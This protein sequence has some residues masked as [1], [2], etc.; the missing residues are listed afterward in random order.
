MPSFT[1]FV[2]VAS[3]RD[4]VCSD[5][6][7]SLFSQASDPSRIFVGVCEQNHK[8]H[9]K[10]ESCNGS[11]YPNVRTISIP[12]Y[13]AAGPTKARWLCST[14]YQGEDFYCQI[15]SHTKFV[16][17]WDRLA[18]DEWTSLNEKVPKPVLSTYP[19]AIEEAGKEGLLEVPVICEAFFN[20]R[21]ILSFKGAELLTRKEPTRSYFVAGGFFFVKGS[22]LEEIP[23]DPYLPFLFVGE[24]ILHS[25]RF[26]THGYDV[27]APSKNLVFHEYTRAEKPKIWSDRAY[28]DDDAVQKVQWYMKLQQ[29]RPP[30]ALMINNDQYGLGT[31]R[32]IE[33]FY[34]AIGVDVTHRHVG[35]NV[36]HGT[37][38]KRKEESKVHH[39]FF[40]SAMVLLVV[41]AFKYK[42]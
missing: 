32:T 35:K 36:C 16:K 3:Y 7:Q 8:D 21:G 18:I 20:P 5:T 1:I 27:F 39:L 2:S 22:F 23:Y 15:D 41:L 10:E 14:L 19:R 31:T 25:A 4:P 34:E 17:D 28:K 29:D 38:I 26:F 9:A 13:E 37:T 24:E 11:M 12:H 33:Q 30:P 6:I 40:L 42:A